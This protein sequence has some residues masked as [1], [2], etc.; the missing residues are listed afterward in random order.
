MGIQFLVKLIF[1]MKRST[2]SVSLRALAVLLM[3]FAAGQLGAQNVGIFQTYI[4][5]DL[6]GA[7]NVFRAGGINSD[8]APVY[9]G[10]NLGTPTSLILN[11]GEVKT[12]KNSGGD[13][14]GAEIF[15]N[16]HP[17]GSGPGPF[18]GIPLP[19]DANLANPG[20][21]R[22]QQALA[23]VDVLNGLAPGNYELE[24]FWKI[25]SNIGDQFDSDFGNNFKASFTVAAP[26]SVP[27]LSQWGL[28]VLGLV[29]LCMG[30]VVLHNRTEQ[31][32]A[33]EA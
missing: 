19:F 29:V 8:L 17:A 25:T 30:A 21:Q 13:V 11:G 6:D 20:D 26:T 7:G 33:L 1:E 24:V 2:L 4:I 10:L 18:N 5:Y 14:F 22:W 12:F 27:T 28:I 15:Y 3:L 31:K 23:G 9:N 32:G 16:V